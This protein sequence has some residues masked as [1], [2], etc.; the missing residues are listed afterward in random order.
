MLGGTGEARRLAE[1][2]A[3]RPELRVV[4][5]LAGRV[6][7][8][9]HPPGEV[10]IGG[11]DG[12]EGLAAWLRV[13][14]V[15][16]V[17]DATHPFAARIT[18]SAA[19]ATAALGVPLLVLQ[20][21]GW[22]EAEGDDWRWVDSVADAAELLPS[23]GTRALLTVGR[24]ELDPFTGLD[25]MWLLARSIEQPTVPIRAVLGRG[26]FTVENELALFREH[27]IDV[28]VTKDS[29]GDDAKLVAA[30]R[31]G[32]PVVIVRRPPQPAATVVSTVDQA[33]NWVILGHAPV[34]T[35]GASG[36]HALRFGLARRTQ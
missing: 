16:A 14:R 4:T 30:R 34:E 20:R 10:R 28:L 22:R 29:G 19:E 13:E 24:Q 23:A 21:P 11:F 7:S 31:L 17:V 9:H 32:V 3:R 8:P 15:D 18:V 6:S 25:R 26:P 2:L 33:A 27:A 5:S 35:V 1:A 12:V 36:A